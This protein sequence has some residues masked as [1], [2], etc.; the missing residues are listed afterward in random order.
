MKECSI[1]E[2]L[3]DDEEGTLTVDD[4]GSEL[5]VCNDCAQWRDG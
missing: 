2:K 3:T 4:D 1:C 5:W